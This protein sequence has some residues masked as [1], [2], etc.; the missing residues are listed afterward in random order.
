MARKTL[1]IQ[2]EC[3]ETTC[4]SSPGK[5]CPYVYTERMGSITFC[6]LFSDQGGGGPF[7]KHMYGQHTSLKDENG[8]LQRH[9]KCIESTLET[10]K[11]AATQDLD[12]LLTPEE[13]GKQLGISRR[14]VLALSKHSVLGVNRTGI[15]QRV[16]IGRRILFLQ[17]HV[18]KFTKELKTNEVQGSKHL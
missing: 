3:G 10:E 16:C 7:G 11:V 14:R 6:K 17:S 1:Q 2:I 12:P 15:L 9:P 8:W 4:A 5:F 18:D 13:V